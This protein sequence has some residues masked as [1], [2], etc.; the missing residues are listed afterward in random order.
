VALPLG[1]RGVAVHGIDISEPKVAQLRAKPGGEQIPVA[2]GDFART[3]VE[4]RFRL[5][6]IVFNAITNL[7]TQDAQVQ[8][9]QNAARHLEP[10]GFFVAEVFVPEL[11]RIARGDRYRAFTV[12]PEH[13][14][15][16]EY[17][18]VEQR[19]TSHHYFVDGGR[20]QLFRSPHRYAWPA[21]LDLMARLAGLS[22]HER[23]AD[24]TRSPFTNEST[25]HISVWRKPG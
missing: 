16:D 12:T 6:Y 1:Q 9:F 11:Q 10:G 21:E 3:S 7:T 20:L 13:L 22:F 17:D 8:C 14:A 24:W 2:I 4:G 5:V 18:V 15:F 23:W 19:C 25:D